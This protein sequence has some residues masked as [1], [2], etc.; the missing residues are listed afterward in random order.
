MPLGG[1]HPN[2]RI[3]SFLGLSK[4]GYSVRL[5]LSILG[6]LA[7]TALVPWI[8]KGEPGMLS[9]IRRSRLIQFLL[10]FT[11]WLLF[12]TAF[13]VIVEAATPRPNLAES[14]MLMLIATA[15]HPAAILLLLLTKL[16]WAALGYAAAM[17]LNV[18]GQ[19][20]VYNVLLDAEQVVIGGIT[21]HTRQIRDFGSL[22]LYLLQS[23]PFFLPIG[24][25]L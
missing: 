6:A 18:A 1:I 14:I 15:I 13:Y 17:A 23:S 24:F 21:Y 22:L 10:G 11:G 2:P 3:W 16:R 8:L 19:F 4:C 7:S 25:G 5:Y 20:L 12:W 9:R